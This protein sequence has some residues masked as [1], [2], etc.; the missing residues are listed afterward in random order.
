MS[1]VDEMNKEL[2]EAITLLKDKDCFCNNPE[3]KVLSAI[4]IVV[5]R[6]ENS[7]PKQTLKDKMKDLKEQYKK[8]LEENSTK[9]FILKCQIEILQELLEEK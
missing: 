1:K 9:A 5:D 4:K 6:A 7:I 2:E 3:E 8:A